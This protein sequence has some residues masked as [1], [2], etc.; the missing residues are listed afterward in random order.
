MAQNTT[1]TTTP[2]PYRIKAHNLESCNCNYGCGCQFSGF[3]DQE[4]CE[5]IIGY[6]V[7]EGYY[8]DLDLAG[9][10][11]VTALKFPKAIHEGHGQAVTF[12]DESTGSAQVEALGKILSGQEGGMPLEALA[13]VVDSF[14]GPVLKPIE[15][16]LDGIRSSFRI[17]GILEVNMK[18][19]IDPVSGEEKEVHI[20]YPKGGFLW[21]DGNICTTETM[22]IDYGELKYQYPGR[23]SGH[24]VIDW[25]NQQ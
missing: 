15:L 16:T 17:P 6:E 2:T 14:E 18:P 8:G 7:I 1:G 9:V 11:Y 13:S 22:Y 4:G 12:V 10:R 25:T 20:V 5:A 3:P 24:A 23:F 21:N 19:L